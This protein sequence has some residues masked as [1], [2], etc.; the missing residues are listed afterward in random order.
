[1]KKFLFSFVALFF[2][3][4]AGCATLRGMGEDIQNLGK[5]L[6]KAVSQNNNDRDR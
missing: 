5:G 2:L 6:K 3:F 4:L 1:M